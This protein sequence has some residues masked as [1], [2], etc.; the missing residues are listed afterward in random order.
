MRKG[1]YN[2]LLIILIAVGFVFS[3][4]L[5][6]QRHTVEQANKTVEMAM[7]YESIARMASAEGIDEKQALRMFKERGVTSLVLFDST[8]QKLREKG[9]VTVVTGSELL[10][11]Y[12]TGQLREDLGRNSPK[13]AVSRRTRPI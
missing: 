2:K 10:H 6:F 5:N 8:L 12:N 11:S 4:F 13:K 9:K 3:L 7:E 1:R